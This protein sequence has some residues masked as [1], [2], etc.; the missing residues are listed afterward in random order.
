MHYQTTFND[1]LS[2]WAEHWH[3]PWFKQ[4]HGH[5]DRD[6][7]FSKYSNS[8]QTTFNEHQNVVRKNATNFQTCTQTGVQNAFFSFSVRLIQF[9]V[10]FWQGRAKN[11]NPFQFKLGYSLK[12]DQSAMG[13]FDPNNILK[14]MSNLKIMRHKKKIIYNINYQETPDI[15]FYLKNIIKSFRPKL[16]FIFM[17]GPIFRS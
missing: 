11:V 3:E 10:T 1:L 16:K 15:I 13:S 14:K 5:S 9:L 12:L 4:K 6:E 8:V 2:S 7:W 17:T